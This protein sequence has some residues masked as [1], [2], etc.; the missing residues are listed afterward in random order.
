[1]M[2]P[3]CPPWMVWYDPWTPPLM[4]F[5]PGWS[6]PAEG[7]DNEG[8]YT[9]GDCYESVG[10]QQ[11]RKA[12]KQE[13]RTVRNA[14]LDHLIFPKATTAS[15][16]Q[17]KQWVPEAVSS[18][19]G[20]GGNQDQTKP[21]SGTS[22]DDEAKHIT[23]KGLEDIVEKQNKAQGEEIQIKADAVANFQQQPNQTV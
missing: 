14:K 20:S 19:D 18:T 15:N 10:H 6:G 11:D 7:F 13:N 23:K 17:Y 1:M 22:A 3:S 4:H 16:Q 12:P 5:H 21:R 8:Y 2:Y 9:G